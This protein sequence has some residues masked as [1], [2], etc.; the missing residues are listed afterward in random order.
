[1]MRILNSYLAATHGTFCMTGQEKVKTTQNVVIRS[2]VT[3]ILYILIQEPH[4]I[5]IK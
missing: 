4:S 1:M 2:K 3:T 5:R